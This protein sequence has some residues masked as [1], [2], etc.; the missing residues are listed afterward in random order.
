MTTKLILAAPNLLQK[1]TDKFFYPHIISFD[2]KTNQWI[3]KSDI[4]NHKGFYVVNLI[5][6]PFIG[7]G[8][9]LHQLIKYFVFKDKSIGIF[10][11]TMFVAYLLMSSFCYGLNIP[12]ICFGKH[13]VAY[14]NTLLKFEKNVKL[15]NLWETA[16][17]KTRHYRLY[18]LTSNFI[19]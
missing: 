5:V 10:V 11:M 16:Y 18:F 1:L 19:S 15:R 6:L 17:N 2:G 4:K 3:M 8:T 7:V 9:V 13:M 12:I 14:V